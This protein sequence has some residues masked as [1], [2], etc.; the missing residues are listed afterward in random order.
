VNA[1]AR[2]LEAH[3][4]NEP[5]E[6]DVAA[7]AAARARFAE[8]FCGQVEIFDRLVGLPDGWTVDGDKATCPDCNRAGGELE[9]IFD[10]PT[11]PLFD[12]L[13]A[14]QPAEQ[15]ALIPA[16]AAKGGHHG[17][18][19]FHSI[20][21]AD[22]VVLR[23]HAGANPV[24]PATDRPVHFLARTADLDELIAALEGIRASLTPKQGEQ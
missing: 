20:V 9:R 2:C 18:R 8:C 13:T 14:D 17:C 1:A 6:H 22:S 11:P 23:I 5:C 7:N 19:I 4:R 12:E 21:A 10:E 16:E 3:D 15:L 24:A